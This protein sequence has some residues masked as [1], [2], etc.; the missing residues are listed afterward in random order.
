[1]LEG[2]E[3]GL[4]FRTG[5]SLFGFW[6]RAMAS[7]ICALASA[8]VP[9]FLFSLGVARLSLG[10]VGWVGAGGVVDGTG[11]PGDVYSGCGGA[12]GAVVEYAGGGV[13]GGGASV[14]MDLGG[15]G[16]SVKMDFGMGNG[17][18][19]TSGSSDTPGGF[20]SG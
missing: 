10:G 3:G 7:N 2:R 18:N 14:K 5:I 1:M 15:F 16:A 9:L 13:F 17:S 11:A 6:P 8:R 12:G 4:P 20:N 19:R